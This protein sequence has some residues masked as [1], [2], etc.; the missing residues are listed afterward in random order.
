VLDD[1]L[2]LRAIAR[3]ESLFSK[4][5]L[6]TSRNL[7]MDSL[8]AGTLASYL[9]G[10]DRFGHRCPARQARIGLAEHLFRGDRLRPESVIDLKR[11]R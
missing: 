10:G 7:R 2:Q 5:N 9:F 8:S 6:K 11:N 1:T 4:C 3:P